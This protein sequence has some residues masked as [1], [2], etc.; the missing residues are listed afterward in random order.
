MDLNHLQ[1]P[2]GNGIGRLAHIYIL[3]YALR[4]TERE[5]P[6]LYE[7]LFMKVETKKPMKAQE[8]TNKK[9]ENKNGNKKKN[10]TK[11]DRQTKQT[12]YTRRIPT[13]EK[14]FR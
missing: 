13:Q 9:R 5:G 1:R 4:E 3:V 11:E 10:V 7:I 14:K 2:I 8:K 12:F 6:L